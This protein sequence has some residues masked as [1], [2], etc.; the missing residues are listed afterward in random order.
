MAVHDIEMQPVGPTFFAG[1]ELF[2]EP[3][4]VGG[5]EAW[6][7]ADRLGAGNH[8]RDHTCH[9]IPKPDVT[10]QVLMLE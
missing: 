5:E 7:N 9:R 3:S 1:L 10:L 4:E 2:S 8:G 6:C